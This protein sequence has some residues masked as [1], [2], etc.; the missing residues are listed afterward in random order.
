MD[1]KVGYNLDN[2]KQLLT[3]MIVKAITWVRNW[4]MPYVCNIYAYVDLAYII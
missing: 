3:S 4:K 1:Y 2:V